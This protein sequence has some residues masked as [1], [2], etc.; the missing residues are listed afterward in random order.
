MSELTC[1]YC[2]G[3]GW[4]DR[5]MECDHK[6]PT[7]VGGGEGAGVLTREEF[8]AQFER[9]NGPAAEA[10]MKAHDAAL[11]A[12]VE[13]LQDRRVQFEASRNEEKARADA[14][15]AEV[16]RL[17]KLVVTGNFDDDAT[18]RTLK[19][20]VAFLSSLIKKAPHGDLCDCDEDGTP[21]Y[22]KHNGCD[23]WKA[24]AEVGK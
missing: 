18:I 20:R 2:G 21:R 23:C 1:I 19:A 13:R 4:I 10:A 8:L 3:L 16:E 7:P 9:S 11:R 6:P 15:E 14:A 22:G 17:K 24:K 5:A 12:E